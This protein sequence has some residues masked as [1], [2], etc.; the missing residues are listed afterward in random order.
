MN[1]TSTS[2]ALAKAERGTHYKLARQMGDT[3]EVIDAIR[4]T[5]EAHGEI[6][7]RR[8]GREHCALQ[9]RI[10]GMPP[11]QDERGRKSER[12]LEGG[13]VISCSKST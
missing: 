10:R 12:Y 3:Y 11:P 13:L 2:P 6:V 7:H 5:A 8:D 9:G 4:S 1:H